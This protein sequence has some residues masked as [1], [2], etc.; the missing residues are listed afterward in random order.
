M[1][2]ENPAVVDPYRGS[3]ARE[4]EAAVPKKGRLRRVLRFLGIGVVVLAVVLVAAHFA[5]KASG[6]NQWKQVIDENGIQIYTKKVP[7]ELL[8][9]IKAVTRLK[10]GLGPSM[11]AL[12]KVDCHEW[13]PGKCS[14]RNIEPYDEKDQAETDY[15][16]GEFPF[17]MAP[18]EWVFRTQFAEDPKTGA[19]SMRV[20]ALP[21]L[22]PP[23][24][25]PECYRVKVLDN[26]WTLTPLPNGELQVEFL[27][28]TDE[29]IP[30]PL[31][32]RVKPRAIHKIFADLPR[33]F[34]REQYKNA[35]KDAWKEY[36]L[37]SQ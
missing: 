4:A 8:R 10:T 19:L 16:V 27:N 34:G 22:L 23:D 14:G 15:F 29:G 17:K 2:N 6:D 37:S 31:M 18:R 5:W 28:H 36:L 13:L 1:T 21:D 12:V 25:C 9:D 11:L 30:Y 20:Y 3:G 33:V 24:T 35:S 7:G 32:N 26:T